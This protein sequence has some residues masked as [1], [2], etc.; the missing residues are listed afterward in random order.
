[1]GGIRPLLRGLPHMPASL[2]V[3]RFKTCLATSE[4]RARALLAAADDLPP[5]GR[6]FPEKLSPPAAGTPLAPLPEPRIKT[7]P[8]SE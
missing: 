8:E 2:Y 1:M 4:T 3:S 7:R 5:E 6:S